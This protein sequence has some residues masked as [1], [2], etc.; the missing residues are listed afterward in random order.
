MV[1]TPKGAQQCSRKHAWARA[2]AEAGMTSQA[3]QKPAAGAAP[4]RAASFRCAGLHH[5][6]AR[7]RQS[8]HQLGA[9]LGTRLQQA[10]AQRERK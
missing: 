10:I 6:R 8:T 3:E 2:L 4:R 1:F 9:Q 7:L 5:W